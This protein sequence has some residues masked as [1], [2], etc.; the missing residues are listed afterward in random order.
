MI[1]ISSDKAPATELTNT[2]VHMSDVP[3]H[4]SSHHAKHLRGVVARVTRRKNRMIKTIKKS[5]VHQREVEDLC[6]KINDFLN[7]GIPPLVHHAITLNLPTC[8][9]ILSLQELLY[10]IMKD[11]PQAQAVDPDML[12]NAQESQTTSSTQQQQHN[13]DR[14]SKGQEV[15]DDEVISDEASPECFGRIEEEEDLMAQI[16]EKEVLVYISAER[17]PNA[18][19]RY[20]WNKDF[21]YLNNGNTKAMKYILSLH[22]IHETPFKEDILEKCLTR[23]KDPSEVYSD[24]KIVEVIRI[25]I[26]KGYGQDFM[27]EIIVNRANG[28][29]YIFLESNNNC[30]IWE[31]IQDYQLGIESYWIKIS[32]TAPTLIIPGIEKLESYTIITDPFNGIV[33]E[34]SKN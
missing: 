23:W 28:K 2:I 6:V 3:F 14:R 10:T 19:E 30:V 24:Q 20:L 4:S 22:T 27:E 8:I 7:D 12:V 33:Y 25:N 21:L 9:L 18:P 29:A 31:R 13:Y 15:D 17:D 32:H 1:D 5:L 16:L 34:N 26:E 11:I